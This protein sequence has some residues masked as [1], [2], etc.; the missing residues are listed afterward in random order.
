MA[1][2]PALVAQVADVRAEAPPQQRQSFEAWAGTEVFHQV[3]SIYAGGMYAPFGSIREDGLRLRAVAGYGAYWYSSPRWTGAG[4]QVLDFR[5]TVS[6]ADLLAGYHKQL[7]SLTI[8]VLAGVTVADRNVNDPEASS[9]TEFGAKAVA[10]TWWNITDTV[11]TSVDLSWTT[12]DNVYGSRARLGWRLAPALSI[13]IEGGAAGT[14]A[15]DTARIGGF[16]RYE[17]EN[18][19]ASLSSGFAGDGPGSGWGNAQGMFATFNLLTRF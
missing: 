17:W 11:W 5:G 12:L 15:Y 19:E 1:A 16:L 10:E 13:G 18:G 14:W 7:G 2:A 9:G 8:K 3:W 6:F 4:T